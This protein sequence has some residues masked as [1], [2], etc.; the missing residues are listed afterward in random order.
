ML[1]LLLKQGD[2]IYGFNFPGFGKGGDPGMST[3][4]VVDA[5]FRVRRVEKRRH[6]IFWMTQTITTSDAAVSFRWLPWVDGKVNYCS[7][8]GND[9]LSGFFSGCWMA[10]YLEDDWR[11]CHITLQA[12]EKDCKAVWR[13]KKTTVASVTEFL[14]HAGIKAEKILGLVTGTGAFYAIGL[15]VS[16][17]LEIKNPWKTDAKWKEEIPGLSDELAA[18]F[19]RKEMVPFSNIYKSFPYLIVKIVGPIEPQRFPE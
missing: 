6:G 12:K 8:Q 1:E 10:R 18:Q 11:V 13:E 15:N 7:A 3:D 9:V 14:P 19:A 17:D 16:N 2:Q 4:G 5:T